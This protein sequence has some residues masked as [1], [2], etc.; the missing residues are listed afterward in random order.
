MW[1]GGRVVLASV[2][3]GNSLEEAQH[4]LADYKARPNANLS[5]LRLSRWVTRC[6]L[7]TTCVDTVIRNQASCNDTDHCTTIEERICVWWMPGRDH[8][9]IWRRTNTNLW[10]TSRCMHVKREASSGELQQQVQVVGRA[11]TLR[12]AEHEPPSECAPRVCR[13]KLTLF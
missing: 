12:P 13:R 6:R 7:G 5:C 4:E 2:G 1:Y 8:W 11:N 10:A 9:W 3:W